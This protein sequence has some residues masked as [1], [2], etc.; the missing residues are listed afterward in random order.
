LILNIDVH[1]EY[2]LSR[3]TDLLLQIEAAH[4]PDQPVQNAQIDFSDVSDFAR[5][6]ADEGVGDR[7]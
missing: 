2:Q 7:I 3:P 6:A 1:L 5:V 4:L